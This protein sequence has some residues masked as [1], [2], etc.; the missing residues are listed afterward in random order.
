MPIGRYVRIDPG[1]P[2]PLATQLSQQLAWLIVSGELSDGDM[3][4]AVRKRGE[5]C[6]RM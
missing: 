1:A 5:P 2:V 6:S 3:L 4:P